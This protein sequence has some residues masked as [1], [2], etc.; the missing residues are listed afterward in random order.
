MAVALPDMKCVCFLYLV[1]LLL[2]QGIDCDKG[3]AGG[4]GILSRRKR[5]LA[6]PEGSTF[7]V[8]W[9]ETIATIMPFDIYFEGVNWGVA[10]PLPNVSTV[11]TYVR[12]KHAK[13]RRHRRDLYS[14]LETIL[15]SNGFRGRSCIYRALCEAPRRFKMKSN[16]L[17][18]EFIR[19][20]FK[21]PLQSVIEDEPEVHS[22]YQWAYRRGRQNNQQ[23]CQE[24]FPE[25]PISLIDLA[26]G[27]YSGTDKT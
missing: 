11:Q 7:V 18:E 12:E 24:M 25:C 22:L 27:Y 15:E 13:R 3:D 14:R 16:S 20:L 19:L 17:S 2:S 10:Y 21:F 8:I 4:G 1:T 26:L 5:Y 6:F 23:E 9:C